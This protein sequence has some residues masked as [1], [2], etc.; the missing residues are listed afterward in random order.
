MAGARAA[1]VLIVATF[2]AFLVV[3]VAFVHSDGGGDASRLAEI[4]PGHP[5]VLLKSGLAEV[6]AKAAAAEP[7][8]AQ[9]LSSLLAVPSKAPMAPEPFLVRGVE[10]QIA[11]N[12]ALALRAF[13]AARQRSPR[14]IAA[15]YFL[16]DHYLRAGQA[17]P[18]LAEIST[19]AR[20]VPQSMPGVV[21]YLAAFA[22]SS[23]AAPQVK[24]LLRRHPQLE[25]ALLELLS[26]DPDNANLIVSLWS[27]RR[28]DREAIWQSRLLAQMVDAGRFEMA[29]E[30]WSR[31][32]GVDAEPGKLFDPAFGTTALP[33]FGWTLA[34][35]P[36]GVAE[37]EGGNRL[38]V[39]FYGRDDLVLAGQMLT[40]KP[41][42]YRLAM[43]VDATTIV[44]NSLQWTVKCLPTSELVG[45]IALSQAGY[46]SA[47]FAIPSANCPAQRLEL[48]GIAQ[49]LP[50]QAD[51]TI[52][53]FRLQ[54]E[55]AL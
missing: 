47:S 8:D 9:I 3:R 16:A 18:G 5:D 11:G 48:S 10:A 15:R 7:I 32:S 39:L 23:D 25:P 30:A 1:A 49:Q 42:R 6:G 31:F 53:Q 26:T 29:R 12:Q 50:Q 33:P 55:G 52:S 41:G 35:G 13:L 51:V 27:G 21:P 38:H 22:R 4:W 44:S 34:S 17:G 36:A 46:L 43:K 28:G 40:L 14:T 2:L 37:A 24:E 54:P 20:L 45:L 19:L